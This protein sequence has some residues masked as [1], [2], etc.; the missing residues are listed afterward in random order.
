MGVLVFR[1]W[2][3][4]FGVGTKCLGDGCQCLGVCAKCLRD[5]Y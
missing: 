4:V 3:P 1:G 5:G 2:V